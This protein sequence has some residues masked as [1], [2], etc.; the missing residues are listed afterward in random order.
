[1]RQSSLGINQSCSNCSRVQ[2]IHFIL[3]QYGTDLDDLMPE[4]YRYVESGQSSS[5]H[6]N[7]YGN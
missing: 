7:L 1:M 4:W 2:I 6:R 5:C 3:Q